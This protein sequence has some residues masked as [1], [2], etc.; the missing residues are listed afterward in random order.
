[1]ADFS[2]RTWIRL[3][4]HVPEPTERE[5]PQNERSAANPDECR[6]SPNPHQLVRTWAVRPTA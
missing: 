2:I 1:M 4:T 6:Q 5:I 3:Y